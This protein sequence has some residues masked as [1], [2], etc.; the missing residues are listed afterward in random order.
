MQFLRKI[1]FRMGRRMQNMNSNWLLMYSTWVWQTTVMF[2]KMEA[3]HIHFVLLILDGFTSSGWY[4]SIY[5]V[6]KCFLTSTNWLHWLAHKLINECI[7]V[8]SKM[9]WFPFLDLSI[10]YL[11]N[12]T[13]SLFSFANCLGM[14]FCSESLLCIL[15]VN[16]VWLWFTHGLHLLVNV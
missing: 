15:V 3:V 12:A 4:K 10:I 8:C 11:I 2:I 14:S 6:K 9:N 13:F 1:P 5:F 16:T 7:L